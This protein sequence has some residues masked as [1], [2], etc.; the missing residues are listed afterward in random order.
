MLPSALPVHHHPRLQAV[1]CQACLI[2]QA[3]SGSTLNGGKLHHLPS[4]VS[5]QE[6]DPAVAEQALSI[7]NDDHSGPFSVTIR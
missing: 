5:Q 1:D 6:P 7:K 3:L 2:K 4:V